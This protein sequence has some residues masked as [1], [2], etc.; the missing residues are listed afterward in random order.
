MSL[1]PSGCMATTRTVPVLA[2]G[3]TALA[4]CWIYVR[5]D[6]PF[7][8]QAPPAAM[9]Y[10]SRDRSGNIRSAIW[11]IMPVSFRPTLMADITYCT[12]PTPA[13]AY[14]GGVAGYMPAGSSSSWPISPPMPAER[15]KGKRRA[16]SRRWRWR[17]S[18]A[19]TRCSRSSARSMAQRRAAPRRAA[20]TE[21]AVDRRSRTWLREKRPSC[22]AATISPRLW[23]TCSSAGR[24]HA[25][26]RRRT[27]LPEQQRGGTS[28]ARHS[29]R[30]KIMAVRRFRP[31]RAKGRRHVQPDRHRQDERY[32]SAGLAGRCPGP[33]ALHPY[34][35]STSCCPGTG[36]S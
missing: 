24:L 15:R 22:R 35:A 19:S 21:R 13:R 25:L 33:P 1:P 3:K 20:G 12:T 29:P 2:K 14:R 17:R 5:D 34:S 18:G 4:R 11:P 30:Q 27:G 26:S 8:G 32:R 36:R 6:R 28:A 16:R 31:R 7:G 9:F 23:T 10:Y